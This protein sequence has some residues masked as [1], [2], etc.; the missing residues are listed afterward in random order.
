MIQIA[1]TR[2]GHDELLFSLKTFLAGMLALFIALRFNFSKPSWA[3]ATVYIVSQPLSGAMTSK[4]LYR[5][6]GT[7]V[8]AAATVLMVPNLVN[9]PELLCLALA[10]WLGVCFFVSQLDRTPRSYFFLLAGYTAAIVGFSS[11]N[12]PGAVFDT[13]VLRVQE[14]ILGITC[15]AVV[16]RVVCPR[17][18]GPV[19]T[20]RIDGW[21]ADAERWTLDVLAGRSADAAS[22]ADA[23]RMAADSVGFVALISY[24][25]YDTSVPPGARGQL[26]ALEQH[27]TALVPLLAAVGDRVTA[28]QQ[29]PGGLPLRMR[30][31]LDRISGWIDDG[32][33]AEAETAERLRWEICRIERSVR[34]AEDWRALLEFNLCT[35]LW[36]L[37]DMWEDCRVLRRNVAEGG[38]TMAGHLATAARIAGEPALHRDYGAAAI[39]TLAA[40][41]GMGLGCVFWIRTGWSEGWVA[42]QLTAIF[43]CIFSVV[44][45]PL[46]IHRAHIWT[47]AATFAAAGFYT[48]KILPRVD[49]FPML[50]LALA[51]YFLASGAL[52]ATDRWRPVALDWIINSCIFLNLDAALSPGVDDFLN[53]NVGAVFAGFL[54]L[55]VI[56]AIRVF[57]AEESARRILRAVW[58]DVARL[59]DGGAVGAA[60]V[61]R[62]V[63]RLGLLVP[64]IGALPPGS[65]VHAADMLAD[66]RVGLNIADVQREQSGLSEREARTAD[67][68]MTALEAHFRGKLADARAVPGRALLAELDAAIAR[69]LDPA[70]RSG[71]GTTLLHAAIGLR[72]CLYPREAAFR[73]AVWQNQ[74]G[75]A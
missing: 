17:H 38:G 49:G 28:L 71:A 63:D 51:P 16:N 34:G 66:L 65:E 31:L 46:P 47:L 52:L 19:L 3:M 1:G 67:A 27:M 45:N 72:R 61:R 37:M 58:A 50:A 48:F 22:K 42:A 25:P 39:S 23:R 15:A 8:G 74:G 5:V 43:C 14:I 57:S 54:G 29:S 4:A 30:S 75:A 59:A 12:D 73:S 68:L 69:L 18:V 9:A 53:N 6:G 13:A 24:L 70:L 41:A 11:V 33:C 40:L 56:A 2:V 20:A 64:R 26:A 60:F 7:F 32:A 21:L 44:D 62:M 10:A 36:D 55:A 35:R